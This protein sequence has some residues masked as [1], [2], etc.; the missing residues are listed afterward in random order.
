MSVVTEVKVKIPAMFQ[1]STGGVTTAEVSGATV[2]ECLTQLSNQFPALRKMLFDE[3]D[4]LSGYLTVIINGQGLKD[5]LINVYNIPVK[6][7]D[8]IYP[9]ILIEGG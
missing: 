8:E 3:G 7:G 9:L 5:S 2:G 4:K 1:S 6:P